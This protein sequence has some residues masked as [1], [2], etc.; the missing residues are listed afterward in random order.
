M[1]APRGLITVMLDIE[2]AVGEVRVRAGSSWIRPD[3]LGRGE[4]FRSEAVDDAA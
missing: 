3:L 4:S 2:D 1:V